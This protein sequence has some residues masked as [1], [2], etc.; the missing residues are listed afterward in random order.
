MKYSLVLGIDAHTFEFF[1][2]SGPTWRKNKPSLFAVPWVVFIDISQDPYLPE[3]VLEFIQ[4]L[5]SQVE[6][7][8]HTWPPKG[9]DYSHWD[10]QTKWTNPQRAKMLAGFCIVPVHVQTPYW[11]KLDVDVLA[12]G[13][14]A[15]IE[16]SWFN[17]NPSIIAP[18]WN[19][20]KPSNQM[21][22]L[23][24][25]AEKT[26]SFFQGTEPLNLHP[27][28]H[29]SILKHKRICS[30]CAFFSTEF[31]KVCANEV[32][33]TCKPGNIPVGSQDGFHWYCATRCGFSI[34]R[35]Q[36]KHRG[37]KL[38]SSLNSMHASLRELGLTL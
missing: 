28:P 3:K 13:M 14:D 29:S 18:S 10:G 20:T 19:Y 33:K 16:P 1:K 25:W 26:N 8:I 38:C 23:D 11:L 9:A 12:T 15:W 35:V 36:M 32:K 22:L 4:E 31:T 27:E 6:V 24:S 34:N 5:D 30:W 17:G 21:L 2:L 37:W 7:T